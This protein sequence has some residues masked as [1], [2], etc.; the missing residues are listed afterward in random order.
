MYFING[1]IEH[2]MKFKNLTEYDTSVTYYSS[3]KVKEI[4]LIRKGLALPDNKTD[5]INYY[6]NKFYQSINSK[7]IKDANKSFYKIWI[8]DS[9]ATDTYFKSGFLKFK[10]FRFDRA[11][12]EFD[13]ALEVEPLMREALLYRGLARIEKYKLANAKP[14]QKNTDAPP[15]TLQ[16]L[17]SIADDE[18]QKICSDLQKAAFVDASDNYVQKAVPEE[19]LNYC[20]A[21]KQAFETPAK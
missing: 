5:N 16:D 4:V 9:T 7:D 8:I 21:K 18:Q 12:D 3:G 19:I 17:I 13:K 10:E 11:I 20:T 14:F 15:V 2:E 1:Q 6:T